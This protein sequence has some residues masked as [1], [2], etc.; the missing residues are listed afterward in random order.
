[1]GESGGEVP[2]GQILT[3]M[4]LVTA[5]KKVIMASKHG[6]LSLPAVSQELGKAGSLLR[7]P[8]ACAFLIACH[9]PCSLCAPHMR[10]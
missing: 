8:V 9:T 2:E 3:D 10:G 5:P 6:R 4:G 7:C 1:M